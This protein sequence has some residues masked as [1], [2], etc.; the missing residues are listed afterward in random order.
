MN[1][2]TQSALLAALKVHH[3]VRPCC[4]G[5]L[6][7]AALMLARVRCAQN[8]SSHELCQR[9]IAHIMLEVLCVMVCAEHTIQNNC[10]NLWQNR[11]DAEC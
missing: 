9:N 8:D 10:V 2:H 11:H 6:E 3:S 1:D 7:P 5:R 4:F